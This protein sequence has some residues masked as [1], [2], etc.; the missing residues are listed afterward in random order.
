MAVPSSVRKSPRKLMATAARRAS[1]APSLPAM[2]LSSISNNTSH[3]QLS[4]GTGTGLAAAN[5]MLPTV[6]LGAFG[7]KSAARIAARR[8]SSMAAQ[9]AVMTGGRSSL[10]GA[11]AG[12]LGAPRRDSPLGASASGGASKTLQHWR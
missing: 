8:E 9:A 4:H 6:A 10:D 1:M 5:G 3:H 12:L 7:A 2:P 11:G